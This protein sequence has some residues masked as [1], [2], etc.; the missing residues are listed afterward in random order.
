LRPPIALIALSFALLIAF[1]RVYLGAHWFSDVAGGLA[2]GTGW[3]AMLGLFY[4]RRPVPALGAAPLMLIAGAALALAG[5]LNIHRRHALDVSR[6]AAL[7]ATPT[8]TAGDWL[9]SGW[10]QLP[11]RRI[12]LTGEIEEPLTVQWAGDLSVIRRGLHDAGWRLPAPWTSSSAL[13]WLT[14]TAKPV[15]LPVIPQLSSGRL[16][17]LTLVLPDG[18]APG[19]SRLVLRLWDAGLNLVNGAPSPL[20]IGSVTQERVERPLSLVSFVSIQD[21]ADTPRGILAGTTGSGRIAHRDVR[22]KDTHW[23][24][25]VLLLRAGHHEKLTPRASAPPP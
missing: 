24:G 1:S 7:R 16:P 13:A 17:S 20:W 2:F 18:A 9:A 22:E 11:A 6:Y 5:G 15:E 4:V 21:D 3:L 12:D 14:A 19:D 10:R 25:A 23:D 8:M